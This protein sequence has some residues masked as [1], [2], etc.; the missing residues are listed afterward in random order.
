VVYSLDTFDHE[1][2][3]DCPRSDAVNVSD[4]PFLEA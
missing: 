1:T 3:A 4:W 2:D